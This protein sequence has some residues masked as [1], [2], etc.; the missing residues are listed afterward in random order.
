MQTTQKTLIN[1]KKVSLLFFL[2][3]TAIHLASSAL[4]NNRIFLKESLILN[5]TM[6]IPLLLTGMIY[7]FASLRLNLTDPEKNHKALDIFLISLI[8]IALIGL[9]IINL[10]I[11]NRLI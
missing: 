3:T 1:I 7:A 2:I 5:K 11:P 4:I 6:D 8:I 10:L 9:I